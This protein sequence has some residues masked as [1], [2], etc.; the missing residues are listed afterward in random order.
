MPA[1]SKILQIPLEIKAELDRKIVEGNFC[2]YDEITA[3]ANERLEEQGLE[4]ILS[5]SGVHRYAKGFEGRL[6]AIK[7]ATEQARAITD[8]VGD[9]E[10]KLS[11]ALI[12]LVQEKAFDVLINLQTD[13]PEEF[14]RIFPKL[15][16]M[17]ARI[18]RASVNQKKW[19]AEAKKKAEKAVENIVQKAAK[20]SLDPE[21]MRIIKEEVYGIF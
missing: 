10:G 20:K 8:A 7:V 19:M 12:S 14:A 2:N 5:R 18:S 3:W 1:R 17:V 16:T 21:T 9:D 15:G 6:A 4:L 13:D 11:D